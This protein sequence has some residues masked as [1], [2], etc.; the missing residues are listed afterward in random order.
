MSLKPQWNNSRAVKERIFIQGTLKLRTPAHFGNGDAG[1]LTGISLLFDPLDD[2]RPLLTG[3]SIAGALRSYLREI[4]NGFGWSENPQLTQ[5]SI[6]ERLFGHLDDVYPIENNRTAKATIESWLVVNDAPGTLPPGAVIEQRDGVAIDGRTRTVEE[7]DHGGHKFDLELLPTGTSFDLSFEFWL[8][9]KNADLLPW[10]IIALKGLQ[11]GNISLGMRKRRGLGKCE[12]QDW[13][14]WRYATSNPKELI[15]W[16]KHD[17]KAGETG[18]KAIT[19]LFNITLPEKDKRDRFVFEGKFSLNNSLLVRSEGAQ[20]DVADMAQLQTWQD[21]Q[22]K[23]VLPGTSLAGI[24]RSRALR[25]ANTLLGREKGKLLTDEIFGRRICSPLDKPSGSRLMVNETLIDGEY[26]ADRVQNRVKIDRF[27]GGCYAQA[28]FSQQPLWAKDNQT[29]IQLHLELRRKRDKNVEDHTRNEADFQAQM[30]LLLLVIKDLWVSDLPV[31]GES[32]VG[33]GLLSGQSG[34]L[35]Y[36]NNLWELFQDADGLKIN[37]DKDRLEAYV[38]SVQGW[39][40][41]ETP[42]GGEK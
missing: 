18:G 21:G 32:G 11:D 4:E 6:A 41:T 39:L 3:A 25:I 27:T 17:G 37:G 10:F 38:T 2:S 19:D 40:P 14:L 24:L 35:Q 34:A 9:E 13:R 5:K 20:D 22:L 28:L 26:I 15:G 31:G 23:P 42:N 8:T 7:D 16:L 33:R 12:I 36:Q 30:G 1:A 29:G